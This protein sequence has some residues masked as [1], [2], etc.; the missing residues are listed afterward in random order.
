MAVGKVDAKHQ[1]W[2]SAPPQMD[3]QQDSDLMP[4]HWSLTNGQWIASTFQT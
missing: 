3:T 1:A 2:D 4:Q